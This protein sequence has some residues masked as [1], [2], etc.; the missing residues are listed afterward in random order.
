MIS[1]GDFGRNKE[2]EISPLKLQTVLAEG[3]VLIRFV[4]NFSAPLC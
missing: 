2:N 3:N 1:E 4:H